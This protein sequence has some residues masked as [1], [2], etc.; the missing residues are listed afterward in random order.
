MR[1]DEGSLGRADAIDEGHDADDSNGPARHTQ[2]AG[3]AH[4]TAET[5]SQHEAGHR[6]GQGPAPDPVH[7]F[8]LFSGLRFRNDLF[9]GSSPAARQ[10]GRHDDHG[11]Q[12]QNELGPKDGPPSPRRNNRSTEGNTKNRAACANQ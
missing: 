5:Q 1:R 11:D 7:L 2:W 8:E 4:L 10:N 9:F 6:E 3:P 12:N